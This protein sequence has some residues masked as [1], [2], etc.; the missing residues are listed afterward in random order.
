MKRREKLKQ[1]DLFFPPEN[2]FK[3]PPT[4]T[5]TDGSEYNGN[6]AMEKSADWSLPIEN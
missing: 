5:L 2:C 1:N 4:N 3:R 6:K